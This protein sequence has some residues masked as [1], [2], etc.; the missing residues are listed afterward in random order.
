MHEEDDLKIA[1][2]QQLQLMDE[3]EVLLRKKED[4][5]SKLK[6][7][8]P[9][10]QYEEK[11]LEGLMEVVHH[12]RDQASRITEIEREIRKYHMMRKTRAQKQTPRQPVATEAEV[13]QVEQ[14][15]LQQLEMRKQLE[16]QWKPHLHQLDEEFA[17]LL[18]EVSLKKEV[19]A[20]LEREERA[21]ETRMAAIRDAEEIAEDRK[22][23]GQLHVSSKLKQQLVDLQEEINSKNTR[24]VN[25]EKL[26]YAFISNEE[27][28][29]APAAAAAAA[30]QEIKKKDEKIV[31]TMHNDKNITKKVEKGLLT[32]KP[33]VKVDQV[34]N[35]DITLPHKKRRY[36]SKDKEAKDSELL[37]L[38]KK[39]PEEERNYRFWE[40]RAETAPFPP[41]KEAKPQEQQNPYFVR[42]RE[43]GFSTDL[44]IPA[45]PT[46]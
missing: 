43:V 30:P 24:K 22:R 40:N 41:S 46:P 36:N 45:L 35:T 11:F 8:L 29:K 28:K 15:I 17:R 10:Q 31:E 27:P 1:K 32:K 7:D 6:E 44:S 20:E 39:F 16:K 5:S 9:Y 37:E 23:I 12:N 2:K 13:V 19:I 18:H 38:N 34:N 14:A 4:K 42:M 21:Y 3:R 25:P 26:K 33:V